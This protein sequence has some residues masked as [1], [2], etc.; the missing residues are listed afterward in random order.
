MI[1][2]SLQPFIVDRP[3]ENW[4]S[5]G[6]PSSPRLRVLRFADQAEQEVAFAAAGIVAQD[7]MTLP[8]DFAWPGVGDIS[9]IGRV[10]DQD[11]G[12]PDENGWPSIVTPPT[13][14]DGW[15]VNVLVPEPP[16]EPV[17]AP[18]VTLAACQAAIDRHVDAV[19]RERH[20]ASAV[21]LASY[22]NST[23]PQWRA[24]AEAF[25]AW[26]D[27]VWAYA[28]AELASVQSGDRAAPETVEA[29]IE[30]LPAIVWPA[31]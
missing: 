4:Q 19:A 21:S 27:A 3:K 13:Y 14:L 5:W 9:I 24:E 16:A 25:V 10:V 22:A 20:Y 7:D 28:L 1:P 8:P 18:A 11:L 30:E 26:R 2:Q 31:S 29:F 6:D 17:A 15:Y 12:E 23:V